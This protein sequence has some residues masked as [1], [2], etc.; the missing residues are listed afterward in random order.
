[1]KLTVV[2]LEMNQP[3]DRIIQI[4]AV[5][6]DLQRSTIE[7]KFDEF[8]NPGEPV[9]PYITDLTGITDEDLSDASSLSDVTKDFWNFVL[10]NN[11]AGRIGGWGSDPWELST[12]AGKCGVSTPDTMVFYDIKKVFK[13]FRCA[14]NLT[15]RTGDG[16]KNTV[17][18]MGMT[19]VGEHHDAFY[20]ALNTAKILIR[21]V[22]RMGTACFE[23]S[24]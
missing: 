18:A 16:L 20:D 1:M 15:V 4:G 12:S 21:A 10:A 24:P 3:S 23:K 17:D 9:S 6:A 2:D 13:F 7:A 5:V 19:F 22:D 14:A 11:C 8:V